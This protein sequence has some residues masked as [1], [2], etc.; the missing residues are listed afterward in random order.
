MA[1]F[2]AKGTE[3][4]YYR[5]YILA[6]DNR[7]ARAV[8][9]ECPDDETAK[10]AAKQLVDGCDVELWQGTRKVETFRHEPR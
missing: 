4:A 6:S 2:G 9:L 10:E 1:S 5:A 3:A 7:I 8:E